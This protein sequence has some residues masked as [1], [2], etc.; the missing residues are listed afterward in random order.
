MRV[1]IA[2]GETDAAATARAQE[3][4][5]DSDAL[6]REGNEALADVGRGGEDDLDVGEALGHPC[7]GCD[8]GAHEPVRLRDVGG[9]HAASG[10]EVAQELRWALGAVQRAGYGG[11]GEPRHEVVLQILA[12]LGGVHE[13]TDPGFGE[14]R[15]R[16]DTREHQGLRGIDRAAAQD[17]LAPSAG[18]AGRA[19]DVDVDP[20]GP[21]LAIAG[22]RESHAT[23]VSVRDDAQVRP[24]RGGPKVGVGCRGAGAAMLGHHRLREPLP[25]GEVCLGDVVSEFASGFEEC[26]CVGPRVALSFHRLRTRPSERGVDGILHVLDAAQH[27][28]HGIPRPAL[29]RGLGPLVVVGGE[30]AHPHHRVQRR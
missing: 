29:A 19:G 24:C 13:V 18:V 15:C 30:P 22:V 14:L 17:H 11:R 5:T 28:Q 7:V 16:P 4:R 20:G 2:R 25:R 3:N 21:R 23:D 8:I 27:R 6:A 26:C 1:R 10:G 9:E 12:D